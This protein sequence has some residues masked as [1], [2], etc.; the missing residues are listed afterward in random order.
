ME[1]PE[2]E[3]TIF[4]RYLNPKNRHGLQMN[5]DEEDFSL[6]SK[7]GELKLFK[8]VNEEGTYRVIEIKT[9]DLMQSDL[10]SDV[11]VLPQNSTNLT[12]SHAV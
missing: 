12:A 6:T 10:T 2:C 5:P 1:L 4:S 9:G 8:C 7:D 3:K 11:S